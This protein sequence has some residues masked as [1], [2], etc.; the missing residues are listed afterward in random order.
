MPKPGTA[1]WP[2][3]GRSSTVSG[4]SQTP[5]DEELPYP[6]RSHPPLAAPGGAVTVASSSIAVF[7]LTRSHC[8][9]LPSRAV[10]SGIGTDRPARRRPAALAHPVPAGAGG[11]RDSDDMTEDDETLQ[12]ASASRVMA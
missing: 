12:T 5:D 3:I 9:R 1:R 2:R 6:T 11:A 8:P 10:L 4:S 7:A